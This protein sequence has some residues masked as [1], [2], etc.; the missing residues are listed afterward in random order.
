MKVRRSLFVVCKSN[1]RR[2][3]CRRGLLLRLQIEGFLDIRNLFG[4]D[5]HDLADIAG[6]DDG[7]GA[8]FQNL[9]A[10]EGIE[11]GRSGDDGALVVHDDHRR[12]IAE[13]LRSALNIDAAG[14]IGQAL[15]VAQADVAFRNG[16][17]IE[18]S[19]GDG[20]R[21][22]GR[23]MGDDD[24]ID[25]RMLIIDC[26][27]QHGGAAGNLAQLTHAVLDAH[28]VLRLQILSVLVIGR[29][30]EGAVAQAHG[31]GALRAGEQALV[32][33]AVDQFAQLAATGALLAGDGAG[34]ELVHLVI[35]AAL[36]HADLGF[37][38]RASLAQ[39]RGVDFE[40]TAEVQ[41]FEGHER[42]E[43]ILRAADDAVVFQQ[44]GVVA[45]FELVGDVCAQLRAAG[46]LVLRHA[47]VAA[48][49]AGVGDQIGVGNLAGETERH[50][51]RRMGMDD[52]L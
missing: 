47:H 18:L 3:Q 25:L 50:Q 37:G 8:V 24:G 6:G 16:A 44:H 2:L 29:D 38:Q 43:Q 27:M 20:K 41:R 12:L 15:H 52:G 34:D 1:P 48:D 36:R 49:L 33:G 14:G 39:L 35:N 7:G 32:I 5:Q 21:H 10:V 23:R 9:E 19:I 26:L 42:A 45:L 28:D 13:D 11:Q 30:Q 17:G 51:R 40:T 22:D 46:H 4:G 31:E